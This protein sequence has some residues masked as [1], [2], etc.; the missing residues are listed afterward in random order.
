MYPRLSAETRSAVASADG[1]APQKDTPLSEA[2]VENKGALGATRGRLLSMGP[3]SGIVDGESPS[4][5]LSY[6]DKAG[7]K[8]TH[9]CAMR[10]QRIYKVRESA[11]ASW[12]AI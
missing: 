5:S 3:E 11:R 8:R 4:I 9:T 1:Q 7:Y 12:H 10:I 6:I 2:D